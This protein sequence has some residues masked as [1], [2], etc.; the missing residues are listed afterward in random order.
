M[1]KTD[2]LRRC[3]ECPGDHLAENDLTHFQAYEIGYGFY[4]NLDV[5]EFNEHAFTQAVK[6][7]YAI[8][9]YWPLNV[10]TL[11]FLEAAEG[12][13][14]ALHK[15]LGYR[16]RFAKV[17]RAGEES[18]NKYNLL[19]LLASPHTIRKRPALFFGNNATA[20]HIW[21]LISGCRW[22]EKDETDVPGV[23]C[24]FQARFQHWIEER[25][26]FS[27][28][29]PWHRTIY[30]ITLGSPDRSLKT[31]FDCFDLFHAGERPD[32]LSQTARNMLNSVVKHCGGEA[33]DLEDAVKRIAPI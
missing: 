21:S 12:R 17:T 14:R 6:E 16:E 13:E 3:C 22:A 27:K 4:G 2:I 7:D 18:T 20:S 9:G 26:P 30:F 23:A 15:Y 11:G 33:S 28:G 19:E 5:E 10:A 32:S 8:Q 25:F 24:T 31:F 1:T 29:I